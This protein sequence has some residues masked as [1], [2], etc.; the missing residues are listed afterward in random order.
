MPTQSAGQI[1]NKLVREMLLQQV[2][3]GQA[4][5]QTK[6]CQ[7][8]FS[9]RW[10]AAHRRESV[11]LHRATAG[12]I[13]RLVKADSV[14]EATILGKCVVNVPRSYYASTRLHVN[15]LTRRERGML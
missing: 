2:Y 6:L 8:R 4:L 7:P 15:I 14:L 13:P 1:L 9:S 3:D 11:N 5:R 12:I 10:N